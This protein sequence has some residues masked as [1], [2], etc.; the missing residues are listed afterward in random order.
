MRRDG[1]NI[2]PPGQYLIRDWVYHVFSRCNPAVPGCFVR[3]LYFSLFIS[4]SNPCPSLVVAYILGSHR[5]GSRYDYFLGFNRPI[6]RQDFHPILLDIVV[7]KYPYDCRSVVFT[8]TRSEWG[9]R[10]TTSTMSDWL[11]LFL[12]AFSRRLLTLLI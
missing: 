3:A 2:I 10:M 12:E 1:N 11:F 9:S 5:Q 7:V 8:R 4:G 6:G